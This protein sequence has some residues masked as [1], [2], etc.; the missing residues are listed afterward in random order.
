M[1][2]RRKILI[3]LTVFF[4]GLVMLLALYGALLA[5]SR[6][7]RIDAGAVIDGGSNAVD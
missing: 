3:A 7:T 1:S 2:E 4:G 5:E 6:Y